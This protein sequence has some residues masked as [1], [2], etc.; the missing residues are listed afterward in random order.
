MNQEEL[1]AAVKEAIRNDGFTVSDIYMKGCDYP[2]GGGWYVACAGETIGSLRHQ[3]GG[4]IFNAEAAQ[5]YII[6]AEEIPILVNRVVMASE[7][8]EEEERKHTDVQ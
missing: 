3:G 4:V 2:Y 7:W 1:M 8:M 5:Y 6:D